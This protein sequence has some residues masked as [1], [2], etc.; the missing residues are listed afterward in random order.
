[1]PILVAAKKIQKGLVQCD[2]FLGPKIIC[3]WK[4]LSKATTSLYLNTKTLEASFGEPVSAPS[5]D[6]HWAVSNN[7]RLVDLIDAAAHGFN[8]VDVFDLK[9]FKEKRNGDNS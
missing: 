6:R 9:Q 1:M 3:L 4:N 8:K 5:I 7:G 2:E